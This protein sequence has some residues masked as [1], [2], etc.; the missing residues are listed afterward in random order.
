M[1]DN[2][3]LQSKT[4]SKNSSK[5]RSTETPTASLSST[6]TS[7]ALDSSKKIETDTK[8]KKAGGLDEIDALFA[9]KKKLK[10]EIAAEKAK[11]EQEKQTA[12]KR[13]NLQHDDSATS[14]SYKKNAKTMK[15]TGNR[16]DLENLKSGEWVDDGLGG[17]FNAD[18]YTGRR[19]ES[20]LK[21]FKAHLFNKKGFGTTKDCPFDCDCCF[22]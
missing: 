19:D 17:K 22:I 3:K 5:I 11:E 6:S 13:R 12:A 2:E 14:D 8:S 20:G 1:G 10:K 15:L 18:G 21:V 4:M 7:P 16:T 9:R